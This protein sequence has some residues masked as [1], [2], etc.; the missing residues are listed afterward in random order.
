MTVLSG[1][2][3]T[4]CGKEHSSNILLLAMA[5]QNYASNPDAFTRMAT[6]NMRYKGN[7]YSAC[8]YINSYNL[9]WLEMMITPKDNENSSVTIN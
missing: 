1:K 9:S 6:M 3:Y 5:F 7:Y 8:S 4:E 2:L